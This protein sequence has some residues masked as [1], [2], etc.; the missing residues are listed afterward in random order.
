[1][2][3]LLALAVLV[4]SA[5][6]KAQGTKLAA[7]KI[8]SPRIGDSELAPVLV[9]GEEIKLPPY[10]KEPVPVFV[11]LWR[12]PV[13]GTCVEET[14]AICSHRYYLAVSDYG[15]GQAPFAVYDL[16]VVGEI[17]GIRWLPRAAR[18]AARLHLVA[19]N[20]P[21]AAMKRQHSL[22]RRT[23]AY[24]LVVSTDSL[25]IKSVP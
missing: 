14:E 4:L 23:Q 18:D 21:A 9:D 10:G 19:V 20:W 17:V 2:K 12:V 24:D 6:A 5:T 3:T 15:E 22:A 8:A 7:T 1:M 16:G 25:S 13:E 11:R